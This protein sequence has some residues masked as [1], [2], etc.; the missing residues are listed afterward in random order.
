M[1][2]ATIGMGIAVIVMGAA[3]Y[4][5][6][7]SN[8]LIE[9]NYL[10][11]SN[12]NDTAAAIRALS[13]LSSCEFP[14]QHQAQAERNILYFKMAMKLK[15]FD[16]RMFTEHEYGHIMAFMVEDIPLAVPAA[17]HN[18]HDD[19]INHILPFAIVI[20]NEV[21]KTYRESK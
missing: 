17:H 2:L 18:Q 10:A 9:E 13:I 6:N 4:Y 14:S 3:L 1:D 15:G 16:L 5:Q 20:K 7:K 21:E 8:K 19:F 12:Q 11:N